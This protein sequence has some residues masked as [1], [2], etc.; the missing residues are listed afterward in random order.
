MATK[1]RLLQRS[2]YCRVAMSIL[3]AG[4]LAVGVA[5]A[6]AADELKTTAQDRTALALTVYQQDLA[7]VSE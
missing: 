6:G 4:W 1:D 7:L 2:G 5:A 3:A